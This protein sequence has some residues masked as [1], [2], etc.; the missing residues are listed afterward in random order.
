MLN[1]VT[2]LNQ[3]QFLTLVKLLD[4]PKQQVEDLFLQAC[5]LFNIENSCLFKQQQVLI[6]N[7]PNS[8]L[9]F[10]AILAEFVVGHVF[11]SHRQILLC[12][13]N[14]RPLFQ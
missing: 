14:L 11:N 3:I 7:G 2:F 1:Y 13:V 6:Q 10:A 5:H 8:V 12:I 9:N 4:E